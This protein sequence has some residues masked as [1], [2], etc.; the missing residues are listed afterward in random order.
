MPAP[1]SSAA[2]DFTERADA[3]GASFI[4]DGDPPAFE[5]HLGHA[6]GSALITCD[7][8]SCAI[9]MV[10]GDLGLSPAARR[11]HIA[12]DIGAAD[13]ALALGDR[14]AATVVLAGYSRLVIDC[15][16]RLDDPSCFVALADGDPV[17]GNARL[18]PAAIGSRVASCYEPYHQ[19][20]TAELLRFHHRGV[21]PALISVH[22]FTPA[23][24]G[25]ARPW[26]VGVL[27][28]KDERIPLALLERL[29]AEPG[30]VVGDNEPYS[31]RHPADYTVDR[32][33]E[34]AGLPH[35][36]IEVRQD[37]L[38]SPAGI[39]RWADI[40]GRAL[41]GILADE[42]LHQVRDPRESRVTEG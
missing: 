3:A 36:C 19:A 41:G 14:L 10:L 8:A 39:A 28:D 15:N 26:H 31:G 23:M 42:S 37:E 11:R 12:W 16:R 4:T 35:V 30:L 32:H 18:T 6:P 2:T 25:V 40:L 38:L 17:P 1:D 22:S 34:R 9:P 5:V 21:V 29:K 27:W 13:L 7:H 20:I 33:A 24:G